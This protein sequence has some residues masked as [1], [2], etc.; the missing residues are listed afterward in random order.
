MCGDRR[1]MIKVMVLDILDS[2]DIYLFFRQK[3]E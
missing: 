2:G 3:E 1:L